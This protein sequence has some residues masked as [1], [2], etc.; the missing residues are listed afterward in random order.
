MKILV[1][2]DDAPFPPRNGVTVPAAAYIR[3]LQPEHQVDCV[4]LIDGRAEMPTENLDATALEVGHCFPIRRWRSS[5]VRRVLGEMLF[6]IPSFHSVSYEAIHGPAPAFE[7]Y[8]A[9]IATPIGALGYVLKNAVPGQRII[10]AIS[11][12][13]TS[14]LSNAGRL[15]R[16]HQRMAGWLRRRR[17]AK[18]ERR[19]LSKC[20]AVI[21]QTAKDISWLREIGGDA[22]VQRSYAISNGVAPEL[23]SANVS[24]DIPRRVVLFASSSFADALYS[25]NLRWFLQNVWPELSRAVPDA[26]LRIAGRGLDT[27]PDLF[28]I[29]QNA[30][31]V[32]VQGFVED[33]AGLYQGVRVLVAPIYK[34]YG[35]INKVAEALALGIPVVGDASAFN[36]LEPSVTAGASS[37]ANSADSFRTQV[38]DLLLDDRRWLEASA[39]GQRF[40]DQHLRW[41]SRKMA[42]MEAVTRT[43]EPEGA[44]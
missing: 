4:A 34:T 14:V 31:Q 15:P 2:C 38:K 24:R 13:Y 28:H 5:T 33:L 17:M 23:L 32:E 37:V 30:P 19:L 18:I 44:L 11:D 3:L 43:H 10:G 8:D 6:A 26:V 35:F 21:V 27:K 42:L 20:S 7:D 22:L 9:V 16:R 36:G 39:A 12:T 25:S 29:A 40:A 1:C 41:E